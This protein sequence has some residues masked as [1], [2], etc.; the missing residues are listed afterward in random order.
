MVAHKVALYSGQLEKHGAARGTVL[1]K[2]SPLRRLRISHTIGDGHSASPGNTL[3]WL[4]DADRADTDW[5]VGKLKRLMS[6]KFKFVRL[7][8]TDGVSWTFSQ[9]KLLFV[10]DAGTTAAAGATVFLFAADFRTSANYSL[11]PLTTHTDR[12]L[13]SID[14]L[15]CD[16]ASKGGE[17]QTSDEL[18]HVDGIWLL[19]LYVPRY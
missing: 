10:V 14:R 13:G 5:A 6:V 1:I 4:V 17:N 18:R 8:R 3:H 15:A 19:S 12:S 9:S 16:E 7:A 11:P 2:A